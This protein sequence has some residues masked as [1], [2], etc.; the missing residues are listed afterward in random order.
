MD[1]NTEQRQKNPNPLWIIWV[2]LITAGFT[3]WA[4]AT[5]Y[6]GKAAQ[7][8]VKDN[9]V[10][11]STSDYAIFN[12][13]MRY[14]EAMYLYDVPKEDM[15]DAAAH[16]FVQGLGDEYSEYFNSE[17]YQDMLIAV[18]G[19]Y[20]GIGVVVFM[21]TDGFLEVVAPYKGTP[22]E[23]AGI[24]P[25][26]I[27][28]RA[29]DLII[30]KETYNDALSYMRG[31]SPE[32]IGH[33]TMELTVIRDNEEVLLTVTREHIELPS[34]EYDEFG[35]IARITISSFE[36]STPKDFK[37]TLDAIDRTKIK[38][39]VLDLRDNPGGIF[40]SA[41]G[42]LEEILPEGLA[43]YT[44]DKQGRREESFVDGIYNDI[45]MAVLIN[46]NSASAS[47]LVSGA[48]Q[49]TDRG[50]VIGTTSFGKGV[51]QTMIPLNNGGALK[52]TTSHYFTPGGNCI[53]DVGITPDIEVEVDTDV[54]SYYL[55]YEEDLQLQKAIEILQ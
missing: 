3:F 5:Y 39:L 45:P 27:I 18:T 22:A 19:N 31:Q 30:T 4:T 51:V 38:G 40:E 17:E 32:S 26:D 14:T 44:E 9:Y 47:E 1:Y 15:L 24:K 13:L 33:D 29:D 46:G 16:G 49:D 54:Y 52:L 23:K 21:N 37:E 28:Y 35:D 42:V 53:Q 25:G 11:D 20:S 50:T 2:V 8:E 6:R 36:E 41:V 7:S 55:T 43:V 34:V 48:I 10:S 12:Q